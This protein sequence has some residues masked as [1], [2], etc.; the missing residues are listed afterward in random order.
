MQDAPSEVLA[1]LLAT[2]HR[3]GQEG[4]PFVIIGAGL[5]SL[6]R[7]LSEARSYAERLFDYR[8]VGPLSPPD[9]AAALLEPA[10]TLGGDYTSAALELILEASSG[11]PYFLQEFGHATWNEAIDNPFTASDAR[12][13]IERGRAQLDGGFYRS[14]WDRATN[15]ERQLLRAMTADSGSPS[16]TSTVADRM[17]KSP[18]GIGPARAAL[19]SKGLIYAPEHGLVAF[20]VPG[21]HDYIQ[22]QHE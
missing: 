8:V 7:T 22:R 20:T 18:S 10:R 9:A 2:Q 12:V 5:P 3:A 16:S 17:G 11:Y 15:A 6:P 14:R 21:M 1:A 13:A 19:I 4:W